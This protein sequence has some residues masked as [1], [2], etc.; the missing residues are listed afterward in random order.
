MLVI[1][2]ATSAR[3]RE[4]GDE[5]N[6]FCG[7]SPFGRR[8][9][10]QRGATMATQA[11]PMPDD[12]RRQASP[13]EPIVHKPLGKAIAEYLV[14]CK[15]LHKDTQRHYRNSLEKQLLP[16]CIA[17]GAEFVSGI[18]LAVL[19][20]F[21]SHRNLGANTATGEL[22][23]LGRFLSFCQ[24]Q[25]WISENPA[26]QIKPPKTI[27]PCDERGKIGNST[28]QGDYAFPPNAWLILK[29]MEGSERKHWSMEDLSKALP[30]KLKYGTINLN[31]RHLIRAKKVDSKRLVLASRR[32]VSREIRQQRYFLT[33]RAAEVQ[34]RDTYSLTMDFI[35][36][37]CMREGHCSRTQGYIAKRIGRTSAGVSIAIGKGRKE[38]P[39]RIN[40]I[41][42][43]Q[44]NTITMVGHAAPEH[45]TRTEANLLTFVTDM[46]ARTGLVSYNRARFAKGSGVDPANVK[47]YL[48]KLRVKAC[49]GIIPGHP[50]I[51]FVPGVVGQFPGEP[52]V[53]SRDEAVLKAMR[54]ELG[55][56]TGSLTYKKMATAIRCSSDSV[57][58]QVR[59]LL[60]NNL[61]FVTQRGPA[62]RPDTYAVAE[63]GS[64]KAPWTQPGLE[65]VI[66]VHT[67]G[68][69][70]KSL[71]ARMKA[72]KKLKNREFEAFA[73]VKP[74]QLRDWLRWRPGKRAYK[75]GS[76]V[77]LQIRATIKLLLEG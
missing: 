74:D 31:L 44:Y 67:V 50:D 70:R 39:P 15:R 33:A 25:R 27:E 75:D 72:G 1:V 5:R 71:F 64:N 14:T 16:F 23:L 46:C 7:G 6:P 29:T 62:K 38:T 30:V 42:H 61:A 49:L 22:E 26:K 65:A 58:A 54:T 43:G 63:L 11:M 34:I 4:P 3:L 41:E 60:R 57:S 17:E 13:T 9:I 52:P 2:L 40:I 10:V 28:A 24:D 53:F 51:Y 18:G 12:E 55:A 66:R 35:E 73:G 68:S 56:G 37:E 8:G 59:N 47:L 76:E 48:E 32:Y 36:Q 77:D 21:R 19:D 20:R 45:L 69:E